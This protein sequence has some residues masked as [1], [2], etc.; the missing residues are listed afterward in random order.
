MIRLAA[1]PGLRA[2]SRRCGTAAGDN[3]VV[4]VTH[5][6]GDLAHTGQSLVVDVRVETTQYLRLFRNS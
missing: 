5:V 3:E 4:D 1:A 2:T 6:G